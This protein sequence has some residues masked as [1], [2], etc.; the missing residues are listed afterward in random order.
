MGDESTP[1]LPGLGGAGTPSNR[2]GQAATELIQTLRDQQLIEPHHVLTIQLVEDLAVVAGKA[3]AKGQAAAMA[4]ATKELR[5]A[6]A[7][8]PVPADAGDALTEFMAKFEE[9]T[10]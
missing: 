3:A 4:M 5:E 8:L 10:K 7:L 1:V 9:A 2:L 6:M